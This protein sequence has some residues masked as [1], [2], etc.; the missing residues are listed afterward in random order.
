LTATTEVALATRLSRADT[1]IYLDYSTADCLRRAMGRVLGSLGKVRSDAAPACPERFDLAFLW[2][3]AM[4]RTSRRARN[5]RLLAGFEGSVV[6][7]AEPAAG[8]A[9]LAGL[10][11]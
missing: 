6:R 8:D 1:V 4:F 11:A 3:V 10:A 5:L 2:Y 9:W 7:L